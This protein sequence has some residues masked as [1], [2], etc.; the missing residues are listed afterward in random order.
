MLAVTKFEEILHL[1]PNL[2]SL[3]VVLIGPNLECSADVSCVWH[4]KT[5]AILVPV[6]YSACFT[7]SC[8]THTHVYTQTVT[9]TRTHMYTI[10]L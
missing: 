1:L 4:R 2:Q 10:S 5:H 7:A 9:H 6:H 3:T 8:R